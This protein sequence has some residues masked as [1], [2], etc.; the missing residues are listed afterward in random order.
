L[1][2]AYRFSPIAYCLLPIAYRLPPGS[3]CPFGWIHLIDTLKAGLL[4][5][6]WFLEIPSGRRPEGKSRTLKFSAATTLLMT[7]KLFAGFAAEAT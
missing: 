3:P 2:I 7:Q 6:L 5:F 4:L 1:P